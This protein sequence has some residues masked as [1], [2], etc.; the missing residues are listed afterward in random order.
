MSCPGNQSGEGL[1]KEQ[2]ADLEQ[3]LNMG[4]SVRLRWG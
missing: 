4:S 2:I 1:S 3:E